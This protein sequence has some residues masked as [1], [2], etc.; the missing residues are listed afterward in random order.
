MLNH[1][2]SLGVSCFKEQWGKNVVYAIGSIIPYT[3]TYIIHNTT[4]H[5][6]QPFYTII[7]TPSSFN[8]ILIY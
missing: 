8:N 4:I 2:I 5:S 3:W 1:P 7:T 6:P